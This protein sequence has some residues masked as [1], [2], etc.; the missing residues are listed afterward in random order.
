MVADGEETS[1]PIDSVLAQ[2]TLSED[3]LRCLRALADGTRL[4]ARLTDTPANFM[5]VDQFI[6]VSGLEPA[7][8]PPSFGA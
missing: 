7:P 1:I 5:H 8:P 6:E 3:E 2:G 4:A